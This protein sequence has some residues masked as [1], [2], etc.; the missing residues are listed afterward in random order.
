MNFDSGNPAS[1]Q[2]FAQV[3]AETVDPGAH[4]G[5]ITSGIGA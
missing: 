5:L 3:G 4:V 1:N 2:L